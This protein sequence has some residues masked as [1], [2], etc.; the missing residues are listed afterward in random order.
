MT[1]TFYAMAWIFLALVS[2]GLAV[3]G[4][5]DAVGLIVLSLAAL[6]LVYELALWS[7]TANAPDPS[8]RVFDRT[9]NFST[10]GRS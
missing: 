7:V 6:T 10:G 2:F 5:L 3:I 9:A 1:K 8:P 4:A